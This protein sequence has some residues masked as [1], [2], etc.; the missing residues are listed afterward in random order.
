M[1][2]HVHW[3]L[4][5][6]SVSLQGSRHHLS[7]HEQVAASEESSSVGSL[8]LQ[9]SLPK[10]ILM[11]LLLRCQLLIDAIC[12]GI[13]MPVEDRF[14]FKNS[15][16]GL[17]IGECDDNWTSSFTTRTTYALGRKGPSV[18]RGSPLQSHVNPLIQPF[19]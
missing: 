13:V 15:R 19:L 6:M 4:L 5:T 3:L 9:K 11:V 1:T 10:C 8:G 12:T 16:A 7:V 2:R 17:S 14:G 18:E